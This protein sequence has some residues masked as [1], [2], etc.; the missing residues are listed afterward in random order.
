MSFEERLTTR[1]STLLSKTV[2]SLGNESAVLR[3]LIIIGLHASG[4]DIRLFA[5]D[6]M[7]SLARINDEAIRSKLMELL[8]GNVEQVLANCLTSVEQN[9][10]TLDHITDDPYLEY[11]V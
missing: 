8:T 7:A 3:A 10:S 2:G 11:D 5:A 1:S 4:K 9:Q 6:I